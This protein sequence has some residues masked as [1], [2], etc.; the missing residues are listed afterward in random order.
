MKIPEVAKELRILAEKHG[1]PRLNELADELRRRKRAPRTG[2]KST[3][4]SSD[5]A[6]AIRE[7]RA[8]N[9]EASQ[10]EIAEHFNINPGRVF[11]VLVGK[12]Q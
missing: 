11:E 1:I 8:E 6:D 4:M 9:P 7:Y 12:R 2:P 10:R 5:L 3:P